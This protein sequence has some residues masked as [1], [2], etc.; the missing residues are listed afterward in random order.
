MELELVHVGVV[1]TVLLEESLLQR[2]GELTETVPEDGQILVSVS[3]TDSADINAANELTLVKDEV[4]EREVTVGDNRVGG[5]GEQ[6]VHLLPDLLDGPAVSLVVKVG[7]I[8]Q[9]VVHSGLGLGE[10]EDSVGVEGAVADGDGVESSQEDGQSIDNVLTG[11]GVLLEN[12][13][14]SL[15][16]DG[17]GEEPGVVGGSDEVLD[18]GQR[19][20]L[21]EPVESDHLVGDVVG[22]RAL[23]VLEEQLGSIGLTVESVDGGTGLANVVSGPLVAVE[24][25]VHVGVKS[26]SGNVGLLLAHCCLCSDV[27]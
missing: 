8:D 25:G 21:G 16:G 17:S 11:V 1:D 24:V 19:H 4:V 7:S 27:M 3:N 22:N 18:G 15:T 23:T 2:G 14:G 13:E 12:L 9:T 26:G 10:S 5:E 20:E 6:L